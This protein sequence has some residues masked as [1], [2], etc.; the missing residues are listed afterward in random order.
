MSCS[1]F[2]ARILAGLF[3]AM[4]PVPLLADELTRSVQEQLQA[5]GAYSGPL[6][7]NAS[8]EFIKALKTYQERHHLPASGVIDRATAKAL[9]DENGLAIPEVSTTPE[10]TPAKSSPVP[11]TPSP[12][13]TATT[14]SQSPS[15][16]G[17]STPV[18]T[19][20]VSPSA[21]PEAPS[22]TPSPLISPT[23]PAEGPSRLKVERVTEF[24]RDFLLASEG[25]S[26]AAQIR[27]YSF[28]VNYFAR[29]KVKEQIV[30]NDILRTMR[31]WPQRSYK[32]T[33]P[34]TVTPV[35]TDTATTEFT[36]AYTLQRGKQRTTGR[37]SNRVTL[38]EIKGELKIVTIKLRA[39]D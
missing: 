36:V 2:A 24:L 17:L 1:D 39:R 25:K 13:P 35:G 7:G 18:P 14:P 8:S 19:S 26:V 27:Y 30:R 28:P 10:E 23:P 5:Q 4:L 15:P 34:V 11:S 21:P 3:L 33:E 9:D 22:P 6:D 29:G 16:P 38:R 32:L 20:P 31:R 12:T 37:R